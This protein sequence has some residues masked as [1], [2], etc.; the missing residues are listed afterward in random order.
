VYS[1]GHANPLQ[2]TG[3]AQIWEN[4]HNAYPNTVGPVKRVALESNP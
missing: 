1:P 2:D 4:L 3:A